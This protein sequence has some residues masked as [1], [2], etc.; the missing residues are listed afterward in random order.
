M[1]LATTRRTTTPSSG[2]A[3]HSRFVPDTPH[4]ASTFAEDFEAV[5][6]INES[7]SSLVML[8]LGSGPQRRWLATVVVG[9]QLRPPEGKRPMFTG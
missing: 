5:P 1:G 8:V 9:R 6:I 2:D 3:A 4:K 7:A